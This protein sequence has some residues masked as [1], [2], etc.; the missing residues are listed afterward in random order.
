MS[1]ILLDE[2]TP[3]KS[4]RRRQVVLLV[5]AAAFGAGLA[6]L[7]PD[8][9]P[10]GPGS[11]VLVYEGEPIIDV[12]VPIGASGP[13]SL[14]GES[15]SLEILLEFPE[16]IPNRGAIEAEITVKQDGEIVQPDLDALGLQVHL[17]DGREEVVPVT[18]WNETERRLEALRRPTQGSAVV[19]GLLGFV[20]VLW[21]TEALPL[22][23]TS[24]IVPV[25]LVFAG[26]AEATDATAPFFNP[27]IVLFFAGF[28]M[29]EA[30]RRSALDHYAS[31]W[32]TARAGR[33][34]ATLFGVMLAFTA[35][36]SMWMSNT[37]ATAVLVPIALAVTAPLPQ[38]GFR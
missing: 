3:V 18:R 32:I 1:P 33:S 22:F 10:D 37:A 19:L 28:L 8:D 23:V 16:G 27:I 7:A 15:E 20:A 9:W 12:P 25:V 4:S 17:S 13:V 6:Y 14:E 26:V 2:N 30:M 36:M 5:V 35:F 34:A 11:A 24:L 21:V 29:A 38:E 31:A